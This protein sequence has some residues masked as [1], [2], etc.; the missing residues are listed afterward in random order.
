MKK[1]I[2]LLIC[3]IFSTQC[4]AGIPGADYHP[5]ASS[6]TIGTLPVNCGGTAATTGTAAINNLITGSPSVGNIVVYNG[7]NW[8]PAAA[9]SNY[10][11]TGADG[12]VTIS[13]STNL[14]SITDGPAI[15]QNYSSLT[16]NS[17]QI[18]SV[19][20]RCK[21]LI[22]YVTGNCT[23]NGT[24]SMNG[25]GAN[26]S[27]SSTNIIE[28][29]SATDGITTGVGPVTTTTYNTPAT[30]GSGGAG[31]SAIPATT[32]SAGGTSTNAPGGG[33]GGGSGFNAA[34][35]NGTAGTSFCGGSGGG[36]G[37]YNG[38]T[39]GNASTNGGTGGAGANCANGPGAGGGAGNP[40]GSGGTG[41]AGTSGSTGGGGGGGYLVLIVGGNLTI[42]SSG[43]ISSNGGNGGNGG[44]GGDGIGGSSG[45]GGAGGGA[46]WIFYQGT[47][48]NTGTVQANG[49]TGGVKA[50]T[51]GG[52][53]G[54]G[55]AGS[56][57]LAQIL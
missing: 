29:S 47:L 33:G 41:S 42:G 53:G 7:T 55:G 57:T 43:V 4:F 35:G 31:A 10:F 21:G 52:T 51:Q 9:A 40:G 3:L 48:S 20:N 13:S 46:V 34:G 32:G 24:I 27:G 16:V 6:P 8:V 49:G 38:V 23:V 26:A 37:S 19:S 54:A 15:I 28:Y 5:T 18:L 50:N 56:A 17:G 30:G 2:S 11:G 39:G 22:I 14:T 44:T 36:G 25:L 1:L 12:A 45:G